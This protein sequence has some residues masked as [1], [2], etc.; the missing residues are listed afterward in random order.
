VNLS[1][2]ELLLSRGADPLVEDSVSV[3][4]CPSVCLRFV[5]LRSGSPSFLQNGT[6]PFSLCCGSGSVKAV[7]LFLAHGVDIK[8]RDE[9]G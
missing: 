9:V 7:R 8:T 5:C 1:V 4:V 2:I 6:S 3:S